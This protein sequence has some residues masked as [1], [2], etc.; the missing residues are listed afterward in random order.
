MNSGFP[1]NLQSVPQVAISSAGWHY[2]PSNRPTSANPQSPHNTDNCTPA[3]RKNHSLR[4][5]CSARQTPRR[6]TAMR[7]KWRPQSRPHSPG[8]QA[9][10]AQMALR[11]LRRGSASFGPRYR[12]IGGVLPHRFPDTPGTYGPSL[13][14]YQDS[15][16]KTATFDTGAAEPRRR[17]TCAY[18]DRAERSHSLPAPADCDARRVAART[19]SQIGPHRPCRALPPVPRSPP[20]SPKHNRAHRCSNPHIPCR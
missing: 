3:R 14:P 19:F 15:N 6:R 8:G 7:S 9:R 5:N 20:C 17:D 11:Q 13:P 1:A 4:C 16:P 18:G 2:R 12:P 10:N